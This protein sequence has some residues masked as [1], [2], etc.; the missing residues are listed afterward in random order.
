MPRGISDLLREYA[1]HS[2]GRIR[3]VQQD[4]ARAN[5][6][7]SVEELG[8]VPWQIQ[9]IE[10]NEPVVATVFSGI[11]IEY[12]DRAAIIPLVLSPYT[13]EYDLSSRILALVRNAPRV[14]GVM[15]ADAN[16][17]WHADFSRLNSSLFLAG[18]NVIPISPG[19]PIPEAL[20]A[21]FILGGIEDLNEFD[22]FLIDRYITGGGNVLFAVDGVFVDTLGNLQ[23]WHP[24][25]G[26]LIAVLANYGVFLSGALTLDTSALNLTFQTHGPGGAQ[27]VSVPYPHWIS[28]REGN[29]NHSLTA[30]FSGL[31]IFWASPLELMPPD[32]VSAEILFTSTEQAWLQMDN[33]ITDPGAPSF[34]EEG[35]IRRHGTK[36]LGAALSGIFPSAFEGH[37]FFAP[38]IVSAF[39]PPAPRPARIVVVGDTD[40]ASDIMEV[41]QSETRNL[42]FLIRTA[43][44]LSGNDGLLDIRGREGVGRLDRI[45][46]A[47]I[48]NA[49]MTFSLFTNI[50]LVP[51]AV[52]LTGFILIRKR[53]ASLRRNQKRGG[54][55][56]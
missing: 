14:L 25:D 29:T 41:T 37:E 12:L 36:I 19:E 22:L 2:R 45:A 26:G 24:L 8:I 44:W 3:V 23:A 49:V 10:N 46:D 47:E 13:L 40:F 17:Q 51:L 28:V 53:S 11:L 32:G 5:I 35:Q 30:A 39:P 42:D 20:P 38:A 18:F 33:F 9:I 52:A 50:V 34:F 6:V 54:D 43:D 1:S 48:R 55:T 7:R 27:I 21:L 31:D 15:V 4:P 16:K 56:R